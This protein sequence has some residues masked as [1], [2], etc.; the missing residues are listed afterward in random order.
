MLTGVAKRLLVVAVVVVGAAVGG[1][2]AVAECPWTSA[3]CTRV[4]GSPTANENY[5][6][7]SRG[8]GS[9][10]E[11]EYACRDGSYMNCAEHE[12]ATGQVCMPGSAIDYQNY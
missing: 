9:C 1:A 8:S 3:G 11:C 12:D 4:G 7:C 5:A 6:Y 10:Y 2:V